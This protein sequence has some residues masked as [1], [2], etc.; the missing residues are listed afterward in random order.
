MFTFTAAFHTGGGHL[1]LSLATA[2]LIC[3]VGVFVFAIIVYDAYRTYWSD[4]G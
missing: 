4:F 1:P 3:G 2:L